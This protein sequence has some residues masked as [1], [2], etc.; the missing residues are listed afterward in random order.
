MECPSCF[1][2]YDEKLKIPRSFIKTKNY[3]KCLDL[4]CGHTYCE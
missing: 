2:F 3:Y 1:D 4:P